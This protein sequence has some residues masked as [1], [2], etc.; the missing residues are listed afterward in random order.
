MPPWSAVPSGPCLAGDPPFAPPLALTPPGTEEGKRGPGRTHA[1]THTHT[2]QAYPVP[3]A[4]RPGKRHPC[5]THP[6]G[7]S[8][9]RRCKGAGF[10]R[11]H[12]KDLE[13]NSFGEDRILAWRAKLPRNALRPRPSGLRRTTPREELSPVGCISAS[14][15]CRL[16]CSSEGWYLELDVTSPCLQKRDRQ[17]EKPFR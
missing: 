15:S 16:C 9:P 6:G 1:E 10:L 8:H 2:P 17:R 7:C 14:L 12:F 13:E 11:W 4:G 5:Q 3:E